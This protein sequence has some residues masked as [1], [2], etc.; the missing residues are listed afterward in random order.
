MSASF[1][2]RYPTMRERQSNVTYGERSREP[3]FV[4]KGNMTRRGVWR[5]KKRGGKSKQRVCKMNLS[6]EM[7][8]FSKREGVF[9]FLKPWLYTTTASFILVC[10]RRRKKKVK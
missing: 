2:H 10:K 5:W 8:T 3:S 7:L 1:V 9:F 6:Q 4:R